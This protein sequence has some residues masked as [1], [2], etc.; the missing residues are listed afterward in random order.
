MSEGRPTRRGSHVQMPVTYAAVGASKLPD[1]VRF[2]PNGATPYE[3]SLRLGSGQPR[4][5]IASSLLMTWAAQRGAK[6]TVEELESAGPEDYAGPEFADDGTPLA[7]K[8]REEQFAPDG[9]PFIAAGARARIALPGAS[10]RDVL[11]IY[12]LSDARQVGFAWGT[13][14]DAGPVG[15]QLF[16]VEHREDDSVWAIGRG[17]L[18]APKSGLFGLKGKAALQ[19]AIEAVT[20]QLEALLPG[21]T[22]E[23][24][25]AT[26]TA[27]ADGDSPHAPGSTPEAS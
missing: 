25:A 27:G 24:S 21:A 22:S 10:A 19:S 11:V 7:P 5:L 1:I 20:A 26:D 6:L 18:A 13:A 16:F 14:D 9:T 2:P 4:F 8:D 3:H 23:G 15:E 12:T 17:F